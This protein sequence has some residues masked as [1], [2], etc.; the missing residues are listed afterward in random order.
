MANEFLDKNGL[1]HLWSK[2]T[3]I[4][5]KK[6]EVEPFYIDCTFTQ[7]GGH[8]SA[9]AT[10]DTPTQAEVD[11]AFAQKRP[12]YLRWEAAGFYVA[13][14]A[15][16]PDGSGG[17][18]YSFVIIVGDTTSTMQFLKGGFYNSHFVAQE[19]IAVVSSESEV[20]QGKITIVV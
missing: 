9:V 2:I 6:D 20:Q 12:I 3:S 5:A 11:S 14:F 4:F 13:L 19:K 7:D 16:T 8:F 18:V 1:S 15:R 17:Y 10:S